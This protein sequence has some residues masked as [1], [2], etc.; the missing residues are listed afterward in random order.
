MWWPP[1]W[2]GSGPRLWWHPQLEL[3]ALMVQECQGEVMAE[4]PDTVESYEG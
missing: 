1:E 3:Q 2:A 4:Y